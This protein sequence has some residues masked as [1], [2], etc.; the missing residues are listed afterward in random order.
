MRIFKNRF[1]GPSGHIQMLFLEI[2]ISTT[3]RLFFQIPL[4]SFT[5]IKFIAVSKDAYSNTRMTST[6]FT[7]PSST[8]HLSCIPYP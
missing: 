4:C 1:H 6:S 8:L 2:P 5:D 3:D 7:I